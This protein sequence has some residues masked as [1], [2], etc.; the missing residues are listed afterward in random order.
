MNQVAEYAINESDL[1]TV[2]TYIRSLFGDLKPTPAHLKLPRFDWYGLATTNYDTL[3][4]DAFLAAGAGSRSLRPL[5][6]NSDRVDD[7]LRD[8]RN[9]LYVKLHG[10][11]TRVNNADCPLILT[12][13]QYIE[14]RKGRARLFDV[15]STWGYEH[16]IIFIG[17]SL[18]DSDLRMI[19]TQLTGDHA[20]VRPRYYLVSPT[21]DEISKRFWES[22]KITTIR[23]DFEG[24]MSA[25]DAAI[26]ASFRHLSIIA[27]DAREH[28]IE[29]KFRTKTGLSKAALQFLQNDV[30]YINALTSTEKVDPRDFYKG[31][32]FGFGAI[33]QDLDAR[34][35]LADSIVSDH[36]LEDPEQLLGETE[37]ILIK[38][39]AGAGKSVV[40]KRIAWET[41]KTY[42]RIALYIKTQGV[43]NVA[44]I[45]ELISSCGQRIYLFIDNAVD[46][47]REIQSLLKNIG[48]E[49]KQ[50]TLIMAERTNEWNTLGQALS[51]YV[52]NEY[53]LRYLS[54]TEIDSHRSPGQE[55]DG[56]DGASNA[57]STSGFASACWR[58]RSISGTSNPVMLISKPKST[59]RR[60]CSSI[61][62]IDS[63]QPAF[64][65]SLL[66]AII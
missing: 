39:H 58:I 27:R 37:V 4:E 1:V 42:D 46:R 35:K 57:S 45:R 3:V 10:C 62:R 32:S 51:A 8:A 44:A 50:L 9:V 12:T 34:R 7:Q 43:I 54:M 20:D 61:A 25:L 26:P 19:I 47:I 40:L 30:D 33:E 48:V 16:P 53:E 18:Q 56:P 59:V 22:K 14:H 60:Y 24:F 52:T 11:I 31:Y 36:V 23:A 64:S 49:G 65:A 66:S 55:I 17:Q 21:S 41:G 15:F 5:I 13:D 6:E 28:D 38:A 2:Q 29:K 63:S